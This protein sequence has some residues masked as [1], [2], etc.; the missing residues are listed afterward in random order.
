MAEKSFITMDIIMDRDARC[1][2]VLKKYRNDVS[3][4]KRN[5]RVLSKIK[6]IELICKN[7]LK[8]CMLKDVVN[9]KYADISFGVG[10]SY[11]WAESWL[12]GNCPYCGKSISIEN[13]TYSCKRCGQILKWKE[14]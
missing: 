8:K 5:I 12:I 7:E 4:G 10:V 2:L 13:S 11:G 1:Y 14:K 6:A 9:Q 3:T